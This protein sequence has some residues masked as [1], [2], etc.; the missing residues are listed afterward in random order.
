MVVCPFKR[1]QRSNTALISCAAIGYEY[2]KVRAPGTTFSFG[3]QSSVQFSI[4]QFGD[5]F[6]DMVVHVAIA[7]AKT[8]IGL[9]PALP[10]AIGADNVLLT[11]ES[12]VSGADNFP[13]A[14]TYTRY[15]HSYVDS[16]GSVLA[17]GAAAS[18]FVRY[19]EYPGQ[20]LFRKVKFDVNGNPLTEVTISFT[21][22]EVTIRPGDNS[23][24]TID[25]NI[26]Q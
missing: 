2:N 7:E 16:A 1:T 4:Q 15:T 22:N 5:F 24:R 10:A 12:S 17:V 26:N 11:A 6:S 14:G 8:T 13:A 20:R 25:T 23:I 18:N 21:L 3:S 19:A 9:V